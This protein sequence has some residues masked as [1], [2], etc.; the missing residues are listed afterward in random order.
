MAKRISVFDSTDQPVKLM[1]F[2]DR[3]AP[4]IQS[5]IKEKGKEE[6]SKPLKIV[7]SLI[8][9]AIPVVLIIKQPDYGTALAFI[10]AT[11]LIDSSFA[12][13]SF[14]TIIALRALIL[15]IFGSF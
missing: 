9:V 5:K 13:L 10:V 11:V 8:V 4:C 12:L 2:G 15:S 14:H 6:I 3:K 7:I 1:T